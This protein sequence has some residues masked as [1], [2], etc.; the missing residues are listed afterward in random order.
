ML[1]LML[2][3]RDMAP[4]RAI[5][6][7][8]AAAEGRRTA[9]RGGDGGQQ[10]Q[11]PAGGQEAGGASELGGGVLAAGREPAAGAAPRNWVAAASMRTGDR[12]K[13]PA[14]YPVD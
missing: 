6:P 7:A 4:R 1:P 12:W 14:R 5:G 2:N 13:D 10:R 3:D 8:P 9:G 11:E